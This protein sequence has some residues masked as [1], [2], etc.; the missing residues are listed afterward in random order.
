MKTE[1]TQVQVAEYVYDELPDS[2]YLPMVLW[3]LFRDKFL[4]IGSHYR[5][6]RCRFFVQ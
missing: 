1:E 6:F 3:S 5:S 2:L 4:P